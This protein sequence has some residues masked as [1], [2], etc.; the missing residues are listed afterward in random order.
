MFSLF[1]IVATHLW[2]IKC[3]MPGRQRSPPNSF[4]TIGRKGVSSP[5]RYPFAY[6]RPSVRPHSLGRDQISEGGSLA[7]QLT[8]KAVRQTKRGHLCAIGRFQAPQRIAALALIG[9]NARA[10]LPER[11][12][13]RPSKQAEARNGGLAR[14]LAGLKPYFVTEANRTNSQLLA[15]LLEWEWTLVPRYSF[16]RARRC[17]CQLAAIW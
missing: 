6:R 13:N 16:A 10:N 9:Y 17:Q 2:L 14:I 11:A 12:A 3:V 7:A 8:A 5:A 15:L 4:C 1:V